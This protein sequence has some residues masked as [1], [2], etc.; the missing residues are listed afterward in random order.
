MNATIF[1][2]PVLTLYRSLNEIAANLAY[3]SREQPTLAM[4][5]VVRDAITGMCSEFDSAIYDVR[6]EVRTLEDKLGM[7]PGE[8]PFDSDVVNTDPK[9]TLSLIETWLRRELE[10]LNTVVKELERGAEREPTL[11]ITYVL[12]A[13]SGANILKAFGEIRE[14]LKFI[15]VK[16]DELQDA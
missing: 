13:E 6:K 15:E 2:E 8:E 9:V 7:H 5:D 4:S 3:I 16:I 12:V 10:R 14:R 1:T 11:V